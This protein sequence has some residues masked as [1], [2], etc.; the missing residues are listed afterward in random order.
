[1]QYSTLD[2]KGSPA[3]EKVLVTPCCSLPACC[4]PHMPQWSRILGTK[5]LSIH[6]CIKAPRARTKVAAY[7]RLLPS[8]CVTLPHQSDATMHAGGRLETLQGWRGAAACSCCPRGS[9]RRQ[10]QQP[11]EKQ[12]LPVYHLRPTVSAVVGAVQAPAP[13]HG[14]LQKAATH[15]GAD[16]P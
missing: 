12:R 6:P 16:P 3:A 2:P 14:R 8:M 4:M 9:L 5:R 11:G 7:N 10:P 13:D 1:M 15:H